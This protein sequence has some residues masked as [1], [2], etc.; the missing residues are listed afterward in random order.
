MTNL[1]PDYRRIGSVGRPTTIKGCVLFTLLG[2]LAA[3]VVGILLVNFVLL[4]WHVRLGR[5]A[6]VPN[7]VGMDQDDAE[8][9][10]KASGFNAGDVQYVADTVY[11]QG[12]VVDTRPKSG[13]R[14]K[15]GRVVGLDISAGQEKTQV[16]E[17]F[18]LPV[19]RAQAAIE[20]AG[21]RVGT[22]QSVSS[23][24]VPEGQVI[25]TDPGAGAK[26][27]KG[28]AV[29]LTVSL[30]SQ[31]AFDMP[32]LTG[33]TLERAKD[34]IINTGLV[35]SETTAAISPEPAGTVLSQDPAESAEVQMGDSVKLTIARS[36]T[37]KPQSKPTGTSTGRTSSSGT[38]PKSTTP[39]TKPKTS[40]KTR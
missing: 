17:V 13:T 21:L 36:G 39:T 16:P 18:R 5:E 26:V 23:T 40:S 19:R 7:L 8:K 4:P 1:R 30:G 33:L 27:N 34:I 15:V 11:P 9:A 6:T 3:F 38:K 28:I 2:A 24:T 29:N 20:N 37:A 32:R 31:G 25:T 10:L 12:K 14:V 22:I 35:L